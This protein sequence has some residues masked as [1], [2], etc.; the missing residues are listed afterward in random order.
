MQPIEVRTA[1]GHDLRRIIAMKLAMFEESGHASALA[2]NARDVIFEDYQRLYVIAEAQH[3]VAEANGAV[4][5]CAGAFLKSDLPFRYFQ[6]PVYGFIGDV[7]TEPEFR[8]RGIAKALNE[9]ALAWLHLKGVTM[10]RLLASEAGR[11]LYAKLGFVASEEMVFS[12]DT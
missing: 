12:G 2:A 3:F 7:F 9:K 1:T 10:V 4:I 5:A 8:S 11:P 6:V